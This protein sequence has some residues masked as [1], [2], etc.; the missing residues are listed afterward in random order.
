MPRARRRRLQ[1]QR[2]KWGVTPKPKVIRFIV[3]GPVTDEQ[4]RVFTAEL[5]MS[6][7]VVLPP[8]FNVEVIGAKLSRRD[9][10]KLARVAERT[11]AR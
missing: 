11:A 9:R 10:R 7:V 5:R 3:R 8:G 6:P 2:K 1:R 4:R